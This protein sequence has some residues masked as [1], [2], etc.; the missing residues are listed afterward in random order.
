MRRHVTLTIIL[1][2]S[3]ILF[4][5]SCQKKDIQAKQQAEEIATAANANNQHGHLQQTKNF[6]SE[7]VL[8]W[9]DLQ[10]RV[11]PTPQ[12]NGSGLGFLSSRFYAYCGIALY[13]SVVPGMPDYQSLSG[14]LTTM[15][16]MPQFQPGVA[17]HWPTCANSALAYMTK[18]FFPHIS[19]NKKTSIDSLENALN[20]VYQNELTASLFQRSV[21]FGKTI[22]QEVF[23]WSKTDGFFSEYP[24]YVLP[25]GPGLWEPTPPGFL[26]AGVLYIFAI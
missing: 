18:I 11:F 5:T 21:E 1:L 26:P 2:M 20:S 6:S 3:F 7:V 14:Q 24:A 12:E 25:A 19:A 17:Y 10:W 8:K 9:I 23:N 13:E 4:V 22:A 15:P 16:V